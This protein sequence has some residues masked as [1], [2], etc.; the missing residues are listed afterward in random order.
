VQ[1]FDSREARNVFMPVFA[2]NMNTAIKPLVGGQMQAGDMTAFGEQEQRVNFLVALLDIHILAMRKCCQDGSAAVDLL[3]MP[4][5]TL[6]GIVATCD[7]PIVVIKASIC[8]KSYLL[9]LYPQV[10]ARK[11]NTFLYTALDRLL[12]SKEQ[13]TMSF[14]LG[15]T[16]MILFDKVYDR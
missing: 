4:F 14:Y 12:Q 13:E 11:L 7:N 10:E 15:N 9:Y 16:M 1:I 2:P 6:T 5:E 8:L 3:F